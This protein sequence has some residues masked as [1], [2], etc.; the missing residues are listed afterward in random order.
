MQEIARKTWL[1]KKNHRQNNAKN[2]EK[3][4]RKK[5]SL[6]M[7]GRRKRREVLEDKRES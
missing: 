3:E 1:D 7:Q 2:S 6:V 4:R 5:W